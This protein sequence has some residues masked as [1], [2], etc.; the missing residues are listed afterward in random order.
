VDV[1]TR[2]LAIEE[3]GRTKAKY[4]RTIDT[5]DWNGL[6]TVF[7]PDCAWDFSDA[8]A[9]NILLRGFTKTG[10]E[11]IV[12]FVRD[13]IHGAITVHHGHMAEIDVVSPTAARGVWSMFDRLWFPEGAPLREIEAYGHYHETYT[14]IGD[15]WLISSVKL[16]RL[17]SIELPW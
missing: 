14:R 1:L 10:P 8:G 4:F 9:K 13:A 17:R 2:L 12:E 15:A 7:T 16:T 6:K 3:I 11:E 5:K